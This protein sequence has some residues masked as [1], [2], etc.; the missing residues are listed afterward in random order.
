LGEAPPPPDPSIS[1]RAALATGTFWGLTVA[2]VASSL[3]SVAAAVHLIPYL[4][5]RNVPSAT[6]AAAVGLMGAMQL[7]GRIL[8]APIRRR[9]RPGWAPAAILSMQAAALA[10]LPWVSGRPGLVL[11]V[12]VFG[13]AS[14]MV[15]LLRAS[16]LAEA[17]GRSHYGRIGGVVASLTTGARAA[18]PI[19]AALAYTALGQ[20]RPV[21]L[22]LAFLLALAAAVSAYSESRSTP[23]RWPRWPPS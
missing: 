5:E 15:T 8:Y 14:G 9:L 11:F 1:L 12:T 7:P 18:G 16:A 21:F 23:R 3:A 19:A 22:G 10:G 4:A 2:V 17:F 20:Y 13:M 6:A